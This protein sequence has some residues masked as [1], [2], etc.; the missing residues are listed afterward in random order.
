MTSVIETDINAI[1]KVISTLFKTSPTLQFGL[2]IFLIN[3]PPHE[4][5][6]KELNKLKNPINGLPIK[7]DIVVRHTKKRSDFYEI[8]KVKLD[9]EIELLNSWGSFDGKIIPMPLNKIFL[10][11][12]NFELHLHF[13]LVYKITLHILLEIIS[14]LKSIL[15]S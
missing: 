7:I 9:D 4:T 12:K 6:I 3:P 1:I 2:K 8:D 13:Y 5:L 10:E 11:V 15:F 14:N